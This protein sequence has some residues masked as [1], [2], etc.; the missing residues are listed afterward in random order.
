M[1]YDQ[2]L[3]HAIIIAT[4]AFQS[5]IADVK[6]LVSGSV[7]KLCKELDDQDTHSSS[8]EAKG[9][10]CNLKK[11]LGCNHPLSYLD[12][13]FEFLIR[14]V[15]ADTDDQ[16]LGLPNPTKEK[17]SIRDFAKLIVDMSRPTNP[18]AIA[19]PLI[20]NGTSPMVFRVA[21]VYMSKFIP[22]HSSQAAETFLQNAL[23]IAANHLH[24]NNIPWHRAGGCGRRFRKPHFESWINLGKVIQLPLKKTLAAN[25][26]NGAAEASHRAQA[27]DS[28][29][30]WSA[31]SISLQ[32]LHDFLSR[33]V[34]PDEFCMESITWDRTEPQDSIN[35]RCYQWAFSEFS[36][37]LPLHQLALIIGIYVSKLVPDLFYN[38]DDRPERDGYHS[39]FAFT[40]AIRAM[41]WSPNT[42]RKGCKVALPF[43]TMVPVYIMSV[44]D[45]S[46]PLYE[47]FDANRSF[48]STWTKKHSNKG[49]GPLL[50]IRLGLAKALTARVWKGGNLSTD[51][52]TLTREEV[53]NFHKNVLN[54]L[55]E[56]EFGPYRLAELLFGSAKA[57]SIGMNTHTYVVNPGQSRST[58]S[59]TDY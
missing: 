12:R 39:A 4:I 45:R 11:W 55:S 52:S 40:L 5:F 42:S 15:I 59:T 3:R 51:W 35:R 37:S 6:T 8:L 7:T 30:A 16:S 23:I 19:A 27:S 26:T 9:R 33:T 24:I 36:M 2:D 47:Y 54:L 20:F 44:F 53:L 22:R 50:L 57:R 17:L 13:A 21:L 31:S 28:R 1:Q 14:S 56:R 29:A 41:K 34:P 48:P 43:I 18:I 32:S 10:R 58:L 46:S 25:T 38:I 49:I